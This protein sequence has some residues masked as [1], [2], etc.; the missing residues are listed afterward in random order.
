MLRNINIAP[1]AAI[2]FGL[3]ALIVVALGM[4]SLSETKTMRKASS[5]VDDNILPSILIVSDIAQSFQRVRTLTLRTLLNRSPQSMARDKETI[6]TLKINLKSYQ[7]KYELLINSNEEKIKYEAFKKS[8]LDYFKIQSKM[9]DFSDRGMVNEG[10]ALTN[11]ELNDYA[12]ASSDLLNGLI[13]LNKQSALNATAL[14]DD[15]Y[16]GAIRG[17]LVAIVLST[18]IT[19][20]LAT[21]LSRSIVLPIQKAVNVAQVIAKRDLV[22]HISID[23]KDEA[24]RLLE[25]L[26][27]MQQSLRD[28]LQHIS[29][30]SNQLTSA[31]EELNTVT[32]ESTKVLHQQTQEVEQAATAVTEMSTAVEGVARNAVETSEAS[33]Q[34]DTL[35]QHGCEQVLKAISSISSLTEDVTATSGQV[36]QLANNVRDIS[37]VLDVIRAIAEQTNLLA[38]NAA[39]EAARAG[40]AG[41]GFAV[42]ADEVR[43]LA[44]RTQQSTQEIEQMINSIQAGTTQAVSS[45]QNSHAKACTTLEVAQAAGNALSEITASISQIN[46]RN[47]LIASASEEQAQVSREVDKNLVNIRDLS[48]QTSAGANQTNS[49]SQELS[50]LAIDLNAV[51]SRFKL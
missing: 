34:A 46:E 16:Q 2:G 32:E 10:I 11:S 15:V 19:V 39:I 20:V 1:R 12:Q 45:M 6:E 5:E 27:S 33:K 25:A 44:H 23:G 3:M 37:K 17:I 40:D 13:E 24:T 50:R 30:S 26:N 47:L 28:T 14:A 51:V 31:A 7:E 48:I 18:I 8:Q 41:R 4:F 42:V 43:A 36:E 21:L 22:Q 38:L 9:M 35:A 29:A 49:A